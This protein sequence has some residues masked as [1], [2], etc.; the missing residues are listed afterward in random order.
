MDELRWKASLSRID[1]QRDCSAL[2][3]EDSCWLC[4]HLRDWNDVLGALRL[5]LHEEKQG[6]LCLRSPPGRPSILVD[7]KTAPYKAAFF[8]AWLPRKHHCIQALDFTEG[9]PYFRVPAVPDFISTSPS[10]I[11]RIS[12]CG[13]KRGDSSFDWAQLLDCLGATEHLEELCLM[14]LAVSDSLASKLNQLLLTNASCVKSVKLYNTTIDSSASDILMS[15]IPKFEE[16]RELAFGVNVDSPG[17]KNIARMLQCS[18]KLQKLSMAQQAV[19]NGG[20]GAEVTNQ[21]RNEEIVAVVCDILIKNASPTELYCRANGHFF[22]G[23]LKALESNDNLRFLVISCCGFEPLHADS[24]VGAEFGSMLSKNWGLRSLVFEDCI[25]DHEFALMISAGLQQNATLECLNL[26][27]NESSYTAVYNLCGSLTKNNT[28]F[29]KI[30]YFAASRNQRR[31]LSAFLTQN[32]LYGRLEMP[33]FSRDT[34]GLAISLLSSSPRPRDIRIDTKCLHENGFTLLCRE[35]P[36]SDHVRSLTVCLCMPSSAQV[37]SL[38]KLLEKNTSLRCV[39]L[40]SYN[41]LSDT[42]EAALGLCANESVTELTIDATEMDAVCGKQLATLFAENEALSTVVLA[43]DTQVNQDSVDAMSRGLFCNHFI[44]SICIET[45]VSANCSVASLEAA[46]ERNT[47]CLHR[48][49]RFALGLNSGKQC[50][51]AFDLFETK[52]S[53]ISGIMLASGGTETEARQAVVSAR[54]FIRYNYLFINRIVQSSVECYPGDC[55]QIDSLNF[56]CWLAIVSY[57]K[58]SDVIDEK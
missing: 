22:T 31:A 24:V 28:C 58:V 46:V 50:A 25:I 54:Q 48:A 9:N 15:G 29:L 47:T 49:V 30:G 34:P 7:Q 23:I 20:P 21:G 51:Q 12:F 32:K 38:R 18:E 52:A 55:T 6:S 40:E 5:N 16:L 19:D 1:L 10:N 4:E 57:L 42:M 26:S 44:T 37:S 36:K 13:L 53:L 2:A 8:I 33:W 35:L 45:P 41:S 27:G 17:L 14:N 43:C 39:T 56:E 11:H 3:S